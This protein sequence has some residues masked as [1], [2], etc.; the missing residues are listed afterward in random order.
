MG[1]IAKTQQGAD[2][3]EAGLREADRI[4]AVCSDLGIGAVKA[5]NLR[6]QRTLTEPIRV[7]AAN[8]RASASSRSR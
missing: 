2:R 6:R 8:E 5:R 4:A 1:R 7:R 3:V